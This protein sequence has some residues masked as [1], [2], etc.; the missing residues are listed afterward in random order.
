MPDRPGP[1]S[2][3]KTRLL[4]MADADPAEVA[5]PLETRRLLSRRGIVLRARSLRQHAARGVIIN[6]GFSIGLALVTLVRGLVIAR[7]LTRAEYGI[8]GI[9]MASLATLWWLRE[10]GV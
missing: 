4:S 3:P 7:L 6:S 9:L 10:I 2:S 1:D 8:W 5:A